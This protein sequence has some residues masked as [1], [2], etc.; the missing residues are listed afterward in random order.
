MI[1]KSVPAWFPGLFTAWL[2]RMTRPA[3]TTLILIASL[4]TLLW[5][6]EDQHGLRLLQSSYTRILALDM[7]Q[8]A[9]T[10]AADKPVH[11]LNPAE[12][13]RF[14][15]L[16]DHLSRKY[17]VSQDVTYD[18][19]GI[20]HTAG[21]D[22]GLDPLL[23][24]AVMAVE[25]R[26]NPIAESVAGAK[27]LMQVIPGFHQEKFAEFGGDRAVYDPEANIVV[28]AQILKEYFTRTGNLSMALQM[29]A[30]ALKDENDT[31]THRVFGE[32]NRLQAV[33][34]QLPKAAPVR[35][36]TRPQ[37]AAATPL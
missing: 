30:G 33:V 20:A 36:A 13:V 11:A 3:V 23:I 6:L 29:Y 32:L 16:A 1:A 19:V 18:L 27:G 25:S 14:R 22:L 24:I 12:E 15:A 34:T 2:T 10:E 8:P 31:Y 7:F 4:A 35:A 37:P 21:R 9:E 28:G 26:F 17:K 5:V